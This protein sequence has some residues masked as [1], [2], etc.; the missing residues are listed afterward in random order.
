MKKA[1]K[2]LYLVGAVMS[3]VVFFAALF[4]VYVLM[5]R[6][7][8]I[9]NETIENMLAKGTITEE[10]VPQYTA[11]VK[12]IV[13]YMLGSWVVRIFTYSASAAF[14]FV[15]LSGVIK[16]KLNIIGIVLGVL[17]PTIFIPAGILGII[18]DSKK[19]KVELSLK[20]EIELQ[21]EENK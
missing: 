14:G 16:G 20:E 1:S 8:Q 9:V 4:I 3:V 21:R 18:A 17:A 10:E 2:I 11:Y 6:N 19:N 5:T 12:F 15:G 7:A 13:A